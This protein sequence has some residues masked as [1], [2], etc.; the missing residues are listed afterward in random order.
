MGLQAPN[1]NRFLA[2]ALAL[3]GVF[4]FTQLIR[5][6][7]SF[8]EQ[9]THRFTPPEHMFGSQPA[10]ERRSIQGDQ[11]GHRSSP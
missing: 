6:G 9:R 3:V 1:V 5:V 8:E 2:I 10:A 7:L 11:A 4:A